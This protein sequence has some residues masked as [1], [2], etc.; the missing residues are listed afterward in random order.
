MLH[1]GLVKI[2]KKYDKRTGGLIRMPFIQ[3]VLQEPFFKTDVLNKLVKEC[4]AILDHVFSMNISSSLEE[5]KDDNEGPNH[6][7]LSKEIPLCVPKQLADIE[8]MESMYVKLT[9]SALRVLKEV[10]SGSSTLSIFSL[11][12]MQSNALE[13]DW[14]KIPVLEQIAK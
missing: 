1:V 8:H 10:R 7:T 11:P 2:L 6:S 12:P 14:K 3:K 9:S 13:E 4:E 5:T